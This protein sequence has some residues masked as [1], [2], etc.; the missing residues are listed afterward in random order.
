MTSLAAHLTRAA[1][2]CHGVSGTAGR[3]STVGERNRPDA[4]M[5]AMTSASA[6]PA[7]IVQLSDTHFSAR[8]GIPPQW[9]AGARLAARRP[10]GPRRRQRRHRRAGPRR[11]RR[12]GLRPIPARRRAGAARGHPRQPRRRVLRRG[13]RAAGPVAHRSSTPGVPT[14]SSATSP[15]GASSASTPT[16]SAP[17]STTTG[18]P[19]PSPRHDARCSSSSTSRCTTTPTTS[20]RWH[21]PPAR[22]SIASWPAP[23]SASWPAATATAS[24]C[25]RHRRV[26]AVADPGRIHRRAVPARRPADRAASSTSSSADGGHTVAVVRPWA[27]T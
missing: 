7:R 19:T 6:G 12:P 22:P 17:P 11:R 10:A 18:S 3:R 13:G 20:G 15:A 4:R 14:A 8:D 16:G 2:R 25:R 9:P 5:A 26:G 27:L 24:A 23:T 21:R 1:A